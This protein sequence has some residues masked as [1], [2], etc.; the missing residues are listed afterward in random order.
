MSRQ[1]R[2]AAWLVLFFALSAV[3]CA[4]MKKA[5]PIRKPEALLQRGWSF[6][7]PEKELLGMEAG[8]DPVSFSA[9]VVAGEKLVFGSERFGLTVLSRRNGHQLWRRN[10]DGVITAQPLVTEAGIF[11]GTE[12]G[13][14]YSFELGGHEHWHISL[15][16]PVRGAFLMAYQRLFVGTADEALHAVD[17]STGKILW[18]YR[19]PAFGGTSVHGGGNPAAVNG[20]VWLGFSDGS[21]VALNPESGGVESEKQFRDNLKFSDIDARVVGWRD[22][23]LVSTYDG[24]LRFL[25]RDGST[26][27]EFGVGG[28]RAPILGDG[29][30]LYFPSS[31]GAVYA[32]SGNSGKSVWSYPLRR[33]VPTG[34]ALITVKG[35]KLLLLTG[36]EEKVIVL[37]AASGQ[38]LAQSSLGRG[39]GSYGPIAIDAES[40]AFY[41]L[42]HFSRVHE[43]RL[44]M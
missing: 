2:G 5:A 7:E 34:L 6:I 32:I 41:V 8:R 29:D 14:L 31:D 23:M 36:S 19:R 38:L 20:K 42:S 22:G 43:F 17:P 12:A 10:L 35:R 30:L 3:G 13:S 4:S 28:A 18:T 9:P 44:K 33:G 40:G 16:A 15:G 21:L 39:S 1:F 11:A 24:K 27:W 25:R 26:I 37:D